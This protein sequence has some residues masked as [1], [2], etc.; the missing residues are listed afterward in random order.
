MRV[1][2]CAFRAIVSAMLVPQS[3][4]AARA[5]A[6]DSNPSDRWMF[7]VPMVMKMGAG[8]DTAHSQL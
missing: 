3:C 2:E 6:G 1:Q 4:S 5:G 7:G 8:L